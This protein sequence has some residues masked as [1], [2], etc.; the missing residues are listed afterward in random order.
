VVAVRIQVHSRRV[1]MT[2]QGRSPGQVQRVQL[3]A[4]GIVVGTVAAVIAAAV[5][6]G[7]LHAFLCSGSDLEVLSC[8][9]ALELAEA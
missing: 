4:V 8:C 7:S 1:S 9:L 3:Q 5:A 6:V 2:R